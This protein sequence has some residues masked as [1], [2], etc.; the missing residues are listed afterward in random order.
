[1][2]IDFETYKQNL[3]NKSY[4]E[5]REASTRYVVVYGSANSGKSV[6]A[7]QNEIINLLTADYDI[8]FIRKYAADLKD[9]CYALLTQQAKRFGIYDLFIWRFSTGAR[10]IENKATGH[11][12]L[13]KGID[14][15]D[16]LKSIVG[17]K[18]VI[19]EEADKLDFEDFLEL[20]RRARGM[21][22]IQI[23]VIY[24]PISEK[25]WI[26]TT[27]RNPDHVYFK[28]ATILRYTYHD[29]KFCTEQDRQSLE[30]LKLISENHYRIYALG[31]DGI[32]D[33]Q[34]KFAWAFDESKHVPKDQELTKYNHEHITWLSFD[35]NVNP[36]TCTIFQHYDEAVRGIECIKLENSNTTEMCRVI[37]AKYPDAIFKVTG[38][39]TGYNRNTISPDNVTNYHIIQEMLKLNDMQLFVPMKNP[40][41]EDNQ[42]L[43]NAVLLNYNVYLSQACQPLIYDLTYV[44]MNHKKEIIKDRSSDKKY[45]DFLD[46]F[47]YF[48]NVNFDFDFIKKIK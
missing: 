37:K 3:F 19:I 29:N 13:L 11:K 41:I 22:N 8:L 9:S 25:H 40:N 16:K 31:E 5:I 18:R 4:Y 24:N 15:P 32:E 17:I 23:I 35:F 12:I 36:M 10:E 46:N 43:V 42:T 1:M 27:L 6:S 38:D 48:I 20:D 28:N 21:D 14:D 2:I 47:R 39:S 44:E 26:K 34:K 7:H 30:N 45:A 33:K